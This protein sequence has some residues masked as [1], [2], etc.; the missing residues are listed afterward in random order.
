MNT[1]A[2]TQPNVFLCEKGGRGGR[3]TPLLVIY[4]GE[5]YKLLTCAEIRNEEKALRWWSRKTEHLFYSTAA[6][7]ADQILFFGLSLL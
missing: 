4:G 5:G 2:S 7:E 1:A 6:C 3:E